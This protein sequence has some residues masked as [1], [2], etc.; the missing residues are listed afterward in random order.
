ESPSTMAFP[1]NVYPVMSEITA[2]RETAERNSVSFAQDTDVLRSQSHRRPLADSPNF[3]IPKGSVG[4]AWKKVKKGF[5]PSERNRKTAGILSTGTTSSRKLL[6]ASDAETSCRTEMAGTTY[7]ACTYSD[8]THAASNLIVNHNE[9]ERVA[10]KRRSTGTEKEVDGKGD[11]YNVETLD[12]TVDV[13]LPH[14]LTME[15]VVD[16]LQWGGLSDNDIIALF[17]MPP[18]TTIED[19]IKDDEG[20]SDRPKRRSGG[21]ETCPEEEEEEEEEMC[22]T[23]CSLG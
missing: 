20:K 6:S 8:N 16:L 1:L 4:K 19:S 2:L 22:T 13:G 7:S 15:A 17:P 3:L 18:K 12:M 11:D 21:L 23:D 10:G 5:R 14:G 9:D